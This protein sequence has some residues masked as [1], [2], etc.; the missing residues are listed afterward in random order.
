MKT[1]KRFIITEIYQ[2]DLHAADKVLVDTQTNVQ[3]LL[4]QEGS[5]CSC[6][7]LVDQDGKPLLCQNPVELPSSQPKAV[8][9]EKDLI[10]KRSEDEPLK[11]LEIVKPKKRRKNGSKD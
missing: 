2:N 3:Y 6:I 11:K 4:H 9:E 1:K 10:G 5:G 8:Q 7:V